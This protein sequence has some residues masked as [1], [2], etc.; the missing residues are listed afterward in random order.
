M[1]LAPSR[2]PRGERDFQE[3]TGALGKSLDEPARPI[4]DVSPLALKYRDSVQGRRTYALNPL[5][6]EETRDAPIG[7]HGGAAR[8]AARGRVMNELRSSP[9]DRTSVSVAAE[10]P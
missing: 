10:E 6:R 1:S 7:A 2:P 4:A 5:R 9:R 8:G 3:L